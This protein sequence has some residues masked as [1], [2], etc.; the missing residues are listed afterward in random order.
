MTSKLSDIAAAAHTILN[1]IV[2]PC[3]VAAGAPAGLV[4]MGLVYA[5]SAA[6]RADGHYELTLRLGATDP[7]CMMIAVFQREAADRLGAIE[8]V[9]A[10][11][12]Q[13]E[14]REIWTPARF[15]AAYRARLAA[16]RAMTHCAVQPPST[17]NSAPVM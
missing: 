5:L 9:A 13:L 16:R 10:V 11:H 15:S 6:Q 1:S 2:D 12:I 17:T 4:D 8:G 7:R 14:D 3:S